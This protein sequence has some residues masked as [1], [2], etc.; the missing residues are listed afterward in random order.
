MA[1]D[2]D[3]FAALTWAAGFRGMTDQEGAMEWMEQ[4][5]LGAWNGDGNGFALTAEGR[6]RGSELYDT[7]VAV[8][9]TRAARRRTLLW[10]AAAVL[11]LWRLRR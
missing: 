5:G 9:D 3:C 4:R 8:P 11:L 6:E 10:L 7:L 2:E 1:T